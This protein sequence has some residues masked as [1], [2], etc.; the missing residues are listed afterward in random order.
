VDVVAEHALAAEA[1][2]QRG[3]DVD[4]PA[5]VIVGD[6]EQAEE[7]GEADKFG[8][9]LTDNLPDRVGE[10]GGGVGGFSFDGVGLEVEVGSAGQAVGV[11][12]GADDGDDF[13]VEFV[14]GDGVGEVLERSAAA[15]QHDSQAEDVGCGLGLE[16][17]V[18]FGGHAVT[19]LDDEE[20]SKRG[21]GDEAGTLADGRAAFRQCADLPHQL[22]AGQAQRVEGRVAD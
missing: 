13:G 21:T 11:G 9:G 14:T 3:V 10:I 20:R 17:D 12:A 8:T 22:G 7:P 2:E 15:A 16:R 5:G 1:G 4:D 19:I 18:Y 6:F